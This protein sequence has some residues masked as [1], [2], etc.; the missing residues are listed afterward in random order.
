MPTTTTPMTATDRIEKKLLL[1]APRTRVWKA[2]TDSS[3]FGTWFRVKIDG[4]FVPGKASRGQITS[5][6]Q[7]P[8]FRSS[9]ST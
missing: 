7:S 6:R 4:P 5:S 8:N 1:R 9:A 2:L 3:E